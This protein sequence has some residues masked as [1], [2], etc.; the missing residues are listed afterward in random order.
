MDSTPSL[1]A[2]GLARH[3]GGKPRR[4]LEAYFD[5]VR[6]MLEDSTPDIVAHVDLV[7]KFNRG[8]RF[9]DEDSRPYRALMEETIRAVANSGA[10]LEI[11]TGGMARGWTDEPYPSSR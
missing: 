10:I 8:G 4:L 1:F 11:N 6:T 5:A 3:F 2:D 9:F 7:K